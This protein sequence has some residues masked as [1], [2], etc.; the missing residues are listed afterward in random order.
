MTISLADSRVLIVDD[1]EFNRKS[2]AM[3]I[4]K[5]GIVAIEFAVDGLDGLAKVEGFHPDLILLDVDMP[6]LDGLEMCRR[7]RANPA[8]ATL[9]VLFQTA[10]DSDQEQVNCFNA[11][12]SD[13]ISKPIKPGEC[14]ARVRHQLEKRKL[15]N[16]LSAFRERVERELRH[17]QAMQLSLLP[18]KETLEAVGA[19]HGLAISSHFETSSELGGDLWTVFDLDDDHVGFL[20][21]DFAGHG[22]TAAINTF[23]L[24]T[25]FERL[26]DDRYDP[27]VWLTA[28]SAQLKEVLPVGQFATAFYGVLD[29]TT[30]TMLF[31][32]AGA[33][34]PVLGVGVGVGDGISLVDSAG[35]PLGATRRAVYQNRTLSLPKGGF[36]FLYSDALIEC[37]DRQGKAL[38]HD[39]VL[40]LV[41]QAVVEQ[42]GAP[43]DW[44]L[45]RFFGAVDRPLRDDLTA[46]WIERRRD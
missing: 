13:F 21:V 19:R 42:P 3:V 32:T 36:L 1:N 29:I 31:A 35:F 14:V 4:R 8:H 18:E 34:N 15:F 24:H 17:A 43:L 40:T 2:L 46:V 23:R 9:P 20:I 37:Q 28:L 38:E 11:G 5:A 6:N 27:S 44:M 41:R 33:P 22:I 45:D 7:L 16:D 25:V 39:G 26:S 30:D 12:G 10:L